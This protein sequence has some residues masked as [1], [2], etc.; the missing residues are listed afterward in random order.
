MQKF[1]RSY[2]QIFPQ[3]SS[4]YSAAFEKFSNIFSKEFA[5]EDAVAVTKII[6][7]FANG[8]EAVTKNQDP[9]EKEGDSW[10]TSSD[11]KTKYSES[12]ARIVESNLRRF[13]LL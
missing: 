9:D 8:G 2:Q 5:D 3:D 13:I 6:A 10:Q 11:N 1:I 12:I 7:F 4:G